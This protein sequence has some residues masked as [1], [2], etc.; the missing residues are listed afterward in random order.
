M[1]T[2]GKGKARYHFSNLLTVVARECQC[3]YTLSIVIL[4]YLNRVRLHMI[5][6][7]FNHHMWPDSPLYDNCKLRDWVSDWQFL[8][9]CECLCFPGESFCGYSIWI[10]MSIQIGDR[11]DRE[12]RW[13][14]ALLTAGNH[15]GWLSQDQLGGWAHQCMCA[16]FLAVGMKFETILGPGAMEDNLSWTRRYHKYPC[17]IIHCDPSSSSIFPYLS[18]FNNRKNILRTI[19]YVSIYL[20]IYI[21]IQYILTYSYI[22]F[23]PSIILHVSWPEK[24]GTKAGRP[25]FHRQVGL[26]LWW[27]QLEIEDP[28]RFKMLQRNGQAPR[29]EEKNT[30][31]LGPPKKKH[32]TWKCGGGGVLP[33]IQEIPNLEINKFQVLCW[34]SEG[35]W[36]RGRIA[37]PEIPCHITKTK[38]AVFGN[39]K[40]LAKPRRVIV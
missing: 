4:H 20:F 24:Q 39:L 28:R 7:C 2:C 26:D 18:T 21:Y 15:Y 1:C 37:R 17:T 34:F 23:I 32:E 27:K 9:T 30:W 10:P 38:E 35:C 29:M 19:P 8:I 22:P 5:S 12:Q 3:D 6:Y 13:N 14:P 36:G 31:F 40:T 11:K 25:A 33:G 16:G